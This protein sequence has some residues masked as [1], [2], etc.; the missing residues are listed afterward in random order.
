MLKNEEIKTWMSKNVIFYV[1]LF[2]VL[3][4]S[5]KRWNTKKCDKTVKKRDC[6]CSF[7][8]GLRFEHKV[9]KNEEIKTWMSKNVIANVYLFLDLRFEYKALKNEEIWRWNLPVMAGA[10]ARAS[11]TGA[12]T[13][14]R[15]TAPGEREKEPE[16]WPNDCWAR[17]WARACDSFRSGWT[18]CGY[19]G[20]VRE[21]PWKHHQFPMYIPVIR[22]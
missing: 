21:T 11:Q 15:E 9:L 6:W 22:T 17:R 1:Y 5:I 13:G 2:Q 7:L 4:L 12:V 3:D 19:A 8:L 18:W 14:G 20:C 10:G 16:M